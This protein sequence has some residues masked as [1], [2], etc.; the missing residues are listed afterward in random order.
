MSTRKKYRKVKQSPIEGDRKHK[1]E[2]HVVWLGSESLYVDVE[3][4]VKNIEYVFG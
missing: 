3:F 2:E 1:K 4:S